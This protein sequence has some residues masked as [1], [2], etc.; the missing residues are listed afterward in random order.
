[1][2]AKEQT[3]RQDKAEEARR[4]GEKKKGSRNL[5]HKHHRKSRRSQTTSC[6]SRVGTVLLGGSHGLQSPGWIQPTGCGNTREG[7]E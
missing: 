4:P 5:L 2:Y 1:M 6:L 3:V 7:T